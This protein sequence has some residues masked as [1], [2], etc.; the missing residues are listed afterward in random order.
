LVVLAAVVAPWGASTAAHADASN[1]CPTDPSIAWVQ[2]FLNPVD[3]NSF[4]WVGEQTT[5]TSIT[6]DFFASESRTVVNGTNA[7]I[8]GSFTSSVTKTF[9]FNVSAQGGATYTGNKDAVLNKASAMVGGTLTEST[10]TTIGVTATTPIPPGQQAIGS[11]GVGGYDITGND[12]EWESLGDYTSPT[13][14]DSFCW[15]DFTGS[16]T[17][18]APT[19][20][21]GWKVAVEPQP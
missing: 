3:P 13:A 10:A 14:A 2:S 8:T 16:Y 7:P 15:E 11:Y 6:P 17:A 1:G 18:Q 5:V 21:T 9:S 19:A 4:I 20:D 12:N